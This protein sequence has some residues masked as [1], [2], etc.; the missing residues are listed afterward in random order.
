MGLIVELLA[1]GDAAL[2]RDQVAERVA[3]AGT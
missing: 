2:V 1:Q 3:I